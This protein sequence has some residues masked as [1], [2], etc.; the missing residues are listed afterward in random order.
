MEITK[1]ID[2]LEFARK[3]SMLTLDTPI[4]LQYDE[5]CGQEEKRWWAC[6]REHLTVWCL[7]QPTLG[8]PGYERRSPNFSARK[9][10]NNFRRPETLLWLA[11]ALGEDG[12][13]LKNIVAEIKD[14]NFNKALGIIRRK[15][16]LPFDRIISLMEEI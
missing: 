9:M 4:A 15:D 14:N 7:Y 1:D 8:V 5:E 11:E 12:T 10:Y 13:K 16:N 2:V 3:I 6:Q